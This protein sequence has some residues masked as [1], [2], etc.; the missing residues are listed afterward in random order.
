M[1]SE[2][3]LLARERKLLWEGWMLAAALSMTPILASAQGEQ[4]GPKLLCR[5]WMAGE[6][7][8]GAV[9]A[10]LDFTMG[11]QSY[12]RRTVIPRRSCEHDLPSPP[13]TWGRPAAGE[14][15]REPRFPQDR[16][17]STICLS[18]NWPN[19]GPIAATGT[20]LLLGPS[21]LIPWC[22]SSSPFHPPPV[23]LLMNYSQ[24]PLMFWHSPSSWATECLWEEK[25][26][27]SGLFRS[28]LLF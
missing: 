3:H 14:K 17:Q 10:P 8:Q 20:W 5:L 2:H 16:A 7:Q 9:R 23:T 22:F 4:A 28:L 18:S 11:S 1:M 27:T 21:H 12:C 13:S 24:T 19:P 25:K 26:K 15:R 6:K